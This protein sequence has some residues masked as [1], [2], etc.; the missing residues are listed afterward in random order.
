MR[1][2][3][4]LITV[5]LAAVAVG[6]G[7]GDDAAA[8]CDDGG[9]RCNST[10]VERCTGGDWTWLYACA[11]DTVCVDG[12]CPPADPGGPG[13]DASS[14]PCAAADEYEEW[15]WED[16]SGENDAQTGAYTVWWFDDPCAGT[17]DPLE[18]TLHT[19]DDV[20]WY[21]WNIQASQPGC[22]VRP[23][24]AVSP[25]AADYSLAFHA[26]CYWGDPTWTAGPAA[27]AD[28]ACA[29]TGERVVRCTGTGGLDLSDLRCPGQDAG[30]G[31]S[32]T[33]METYLRVQRAEPPAPG[34]CPGSTYT[35]AFD[36]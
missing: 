7:A 18:A 15:A 33:S 30:D 24:L 25:A 6:C 19:A 34:A 13:G 20:D 31:I 35:L 29:I 28:Q 22:G 21:R 11:A 27:P 23:T 5:V 36:F 12:Y 32:H 8:I 14:D 10:N 26:R 4:R 3:C 17:P 2:K 1:W 9:Y 16:I